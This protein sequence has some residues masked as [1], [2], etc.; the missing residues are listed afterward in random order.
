M[1]SPAVLLCCLCVVGLASPIEAAAP[2]DELLRYVPA[3]VTFCL[4]VR[5][6]RAHLSALGNSP[7]AEQLRASP[8]G[9][10]LKASPELEKLL[11]GQEVIEAALGMSLD[12]IRDDILGDSIVFA[13][14][15]GPPGKPELE[16]ELVLLRA[17]EAKP[18]AQLVERLNK[19]L[20]NTGALKEVSEIEHNGFKY[21]RRVEGDE[22]N[23]LCLRGPVLIFSSK[24]SMLREALALEKNTPATREAA[25][26][27]SLRQLGADKALLSIWLNPRGFDAELAAKL[28]KAVDADKAFLKTFLAC[29]KAL[30]GAAVTLSLTRDFEFGL[31]LRGR[32]ESLPV[33]IRRFL[34]D[35]ASLADLWT[36]FPEDSLLAV[37][38][39]TPA[40]SLLAFLGAFQTKKAFESMQEGLTRRVVA[41]VGDKDVVKDV[42]PHV[43]PDWGVCV[44]APP[45]GE[46]AWIPSMLFALRIAAADSAMPIDKA[47]VDLIKLQ[48]GGMAQAY[49]MMRKDPLVW[50]KAAHDRLE[51]AYLDSTT[52]Q[53]MGLQP[54]F[55][56]CDGYLVIA[57]TPETFRR[58][59]AP[60]RPFKSGAEVPLLRLSLSS[61]RQYLK[62]YRGPL[63]SV[64]AEQHQQPPAR[65]GQQL[66]DVGAVLSLVDRLELTQRTIPEQ[67]TFALRLRPAQPLRK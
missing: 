63:V 30:D 11:K 2:A 14:R 25:V 32:P 36:R 13:Y 39:R 59:A 62:E 10:A 42:L 46:K 15:Q 43:G 4:T 66:D 22:V 45:R 6:L 27:R 9:K 38:A 31:A 51:I 12:R 61:L 20:K 58:F 65:V 1:K 24:E 47:L 18:L 53:A 35:A 60:A 41:F 16:Q 8:M 29:W 50:K 44:T 7:F 17:R 40:S 55:G 48:A 33:P 21:Q 64:L 5:D 37:A 34:D 23:F 26:S 67:V 57:S 28:E 19:L 3:D 49:N 56:L 54:A 52:G